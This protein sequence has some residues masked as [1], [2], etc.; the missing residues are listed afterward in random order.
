MSRIPRRRVRHAAIGLIILAA[1]CARKDSAPS[2]DSGAAPAPHSAAALRSTKSAQGSPVFPGALAKP[3]DS[4]SGD[5]FYAFTTQLTYAG[6]HERERDCKN[7]S[8]CGG[9]KPT[10]KTKVQVSAVAT[11]DSLAE[12]NVPEF[13]V[14]YARAIN[15]G[16]EEEARYGFRAD[17]NVRYYVIVQ[18]DSTGGMR[19]RIEELVT[20]APR[21]HTQVASGKLQPCGHAWTPG[22]RADF[23]TCNAP[24]RGDTVVTMGLLLQGSDRDPIWFGCAQGCCTVGP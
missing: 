14:V 12:S 23:K 6:S 18:R 22:A 5:E 19:W 24:E 15:K 17:K 20:L 7:A 11:Q 4:Y 13:G 1:A 21:R 9:A 3:I 8:G 2:A 10:K 16:A